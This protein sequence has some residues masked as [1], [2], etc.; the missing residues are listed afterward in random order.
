C[1]D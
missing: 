1:I